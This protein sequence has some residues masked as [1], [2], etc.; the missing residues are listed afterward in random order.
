MALW[1]LAENHALRRDRGES[2][3]LLALAQ[4]AAPGDP[5]VDGMC[6]PGPA[7]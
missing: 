5:E 1:F 2:E 4:A 3:R 7:P 6:G